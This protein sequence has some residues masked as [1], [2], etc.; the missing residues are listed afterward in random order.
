MFTEACV[1]APRWFRVVYASCL[2]GSGLIISNLLLALSTNWLTYEQRNKRILP[3]NEKK[4][5]F[6]EKLSLA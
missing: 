1:V 4:P 3:A 5:F 2:A 6:L